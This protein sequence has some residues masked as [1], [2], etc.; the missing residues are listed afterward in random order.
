MTEEQFNH[1]NERVS[2]LETATNRLIDFAYQSQRQND[3]RFDELRRSEQRMMSA[4]ETL[5][6]AQIETFA[7][8]DQMQVEIRGLQTE[9]RRILDRLLNQEPPETD[10]A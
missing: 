5:A 6:Q 7:R 2:D 8:I 3:Q 9:N 4:I 10:E 1:L